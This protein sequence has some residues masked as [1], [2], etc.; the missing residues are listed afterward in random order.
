MLHRYSLLGESSVSRAISAA[1]G[2]RLDSRCPEAFAPD[3]ACADNEKSIC[4]TV[5]LLRSACIEA[6]FSLA[7]K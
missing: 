7:S 6:C 1:R 5:S 4:Q 3:K 2:R